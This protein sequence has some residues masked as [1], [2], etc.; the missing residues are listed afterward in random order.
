MPATVI[1]RELA[2][3]FTIRNCEQNPAIDTFIFYNRLF[4]PFITYESLS[5]SSQPYTAEWMHLFVNAVHKFVTFCERSRHAT[6]ILYQLASTNFGKFNLSPLYFRVLCL[7][8]SFTSKMDNKDSTRKDK[9][10]KNVVR[11][12]NLS[13][14][15]DETGY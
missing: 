14:L 1:S 15:N 13:A 11:S 12:S 4:L 7:K 6:V 3:M 10:L 5:D 2:A 9:N 8:A